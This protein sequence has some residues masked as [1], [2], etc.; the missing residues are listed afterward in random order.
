MKFKIFLFIILAFA[1]CFSAVVSV[2]AM[3]EQ[4]RQALIAQLQQQIAI[5]MQQVQQMAAQQQGSSSWCHTFN[6]N[7]GYANSGSVEVLNL[8][9]ALQRQGI[10]YSPDDIYI[11]STATMAA[12]LNFQTRYGITPLTG[13][14]GPKTRIRLNQLYGCG[15]TTNNSYDSTIYKT[16]GCNAECVNQSDG[17]Y[18][19]DCGG[20][21]TK[22]APDQTCQKNYDTSYAYS[23]GSV[24]T[25]KTLNGAECITTCIPNW[26]CT[27]FGP[28]LNSQQA[29]TCTDTNNCSTT[30]NRPEVTQL[31]TS[32]VADCLFQP[33]GT[34]AV[35][36]SGN[37]EMCN[38]TQTCKKI[39]D[40]S[41]TYN[42]GTAQTVQTLSGT[43]CVDKCIPSWQC[44]G[45]GPC[46]N[47]QR[48]Q[49]CVD[50]DNCGTTDGRPN[51][52][53]LCTI[54]NASCKTQSDGIYTIDC[55]GYVSKC[56]EDEICRKVYDTTY[57]HNNGSIQTINTLVGAECY[58]PEE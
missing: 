33:D 27:N 45:L 50:I 55:S 36:C 32:C 14:L 58:T 5:L 9:L 52:S 48:T 18:A 44:S 40:T 53:E 37:T 16:D 56:G 21:P 3:T 26:Q 41:T 30:T 1:F 43:E 46:I 2:Q 13:Y 22:C 8:H 38:I 29:R 31:C 19:V 54:C 17:T 11:Y 25:I 12:V 42:N 6:T 35:D 4:E 51:L 39:Y 24:Q 10:S 47:G 28:C 57:T 20:N 23:S 34:Y 7:L 15:D 49:T